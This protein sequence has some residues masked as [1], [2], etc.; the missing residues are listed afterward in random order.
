MSSF[1]PPPIRLTIHPSTHP[2]IHP[3]ISANQSKESKPKRRQDLDAPTHPPSHSKKSTPL[4]SPA[5]PA[6]PH[7]NPATPVPHSSPSISVQ[8]IVARLT[9]SPTHH[10]TASTPPPIHPRTP[11]NKTYICPH[12]PSP[13]VPPDRKEETNSQDPFRSLSLLTQ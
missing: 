8:L 7:H 10:P 4:C 2:S 1:F 11:A 12:P 6:P 9:P 13:A 3:S 5:C